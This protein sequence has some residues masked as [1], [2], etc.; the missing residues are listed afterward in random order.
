MKY[1]EG[2]FSVLGGEGNSMRCHGVDQY[3]TNLLKKGTKLV[4]CMNAL[5][6]LTLSV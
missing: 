2:V 5:Y 3:F 6:I 1:L 4:R